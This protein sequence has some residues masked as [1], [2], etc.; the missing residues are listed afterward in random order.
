MILK[1]DSI[2]LTRTY[3]Y[4]Q[5]PMAIALMIPTC[6]TPFRN[7][8]Q[9]GAIP[10][11]LQT[12]RPKTSMT[13]LST[14]ENSNSRNQRESQK[15]AVRT[16]VSCNSNLPEIRINAT[17]ETKTNAMETI[18]TMK[19]PFAHQLHGHSDAECCTLTIQKE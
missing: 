13:F 17:K 4:S 10:T 11:L 1:H 7:V 5:D 12:P 9:I 8:F 15:P 16:I 18:A 6:L 14:M 2:N 3:L 19:S